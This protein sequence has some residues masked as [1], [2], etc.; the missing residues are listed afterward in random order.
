N[1]TGKNLA[2]KRNVKTLLSVGGPEGEAHRALVNLTKTEE[3]I[4]IFSYNAISYLRFY[5]FHGL[6]IDWQYPSTLSMKAG[7]IKLLEILRRDFDSNTAGERL[8]LTVKCPG[9]YSSDGYD[10]PLMSRYVDYVVLAAYNLPTPNAM[11]AWFG[12]PLY[13]THISVN[14]SVREWLDEGLPANKTVVGITSVGRF[15]RLL[16]VLRFTPGDP[17]NETLRGNDY[18][19]PGGLAYS[20]I[21]VMLKIVE[22]FFDEAAQMY[23]LVSENTWV[24]YEDFDS[25]TAKIT[26]MKN[27]NLAGVM[28]PEIDMDDFNG[29]V[30]GYGPFPFMNMIKHLSET[31]TTARPSQTSTTTATVTRNETTTAA[32]DVTSTTIIQETTDNPTLRADSTTA[33]NMQAG[34]TN[35]STVTIF[36]IFLA[37][38]VFAT[39]V[40]CLAR[41]HSM[42]DKHRLQEQISHR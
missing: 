13:S 21:C 22:T 38:C 40:V 24:G 37:M 41:K 34:T 36:A 18:N 3:Q 10:V 31:I 20:E 42:S 19:I 32:T 1:F 28:F 33:D 29:T 2:T 4:S 25:I 7:L 15:L 35:H 9:V 27:L 8:L 12:S 39:V 23:Y 26:W 6:D 17:I 11:Q 16:D 30:C 14:S 5:G